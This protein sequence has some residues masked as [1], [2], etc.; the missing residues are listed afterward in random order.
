MR[1]FVTG[2]TGYIGTAVVTHLVKA[3]HQVTGLV[4]SPAKAQQLEALGATA[5]QGEVKDAASFNAVAVEHDGIIHTGFE[6]GPEGTAVD[7]K[8][9][10][11]GMHWCYPAAPQRPSNRRSVHAQPEDSSSPLLGS[12]RSAT[13]I[14]APSPS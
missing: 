10:S 6:Y 9:V 11:G 13:S 7:K 3:G 8:A 12:V 1:V 14:A 2:S 4:R 5:V